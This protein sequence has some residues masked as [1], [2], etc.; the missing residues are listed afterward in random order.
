MR[1]NLPI[2][3]LIM[4]KHLPLLLTILLACSCGSNDPSADAESEWCYLDFGFHDTKNGDLKPVIE[5][6]DNE[7]K[8]LV[9]DEIK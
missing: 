5:A 6:V 8:R 1:S 2:H 9:S 4:L 3:P 7:C